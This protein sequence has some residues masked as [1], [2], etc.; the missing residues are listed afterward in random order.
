MSKLFYLVDFNFRDKI[1][2]IQWLRY[3]WEATRE[4]LADRT[5]LGVTRSELYQMNPGFT[6]PMGEDRDRS[7]SNIREIYRYIQENGKQVVPEVSNA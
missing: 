2:M 5:A 3:E 6:S 7:D 4:L 1:K